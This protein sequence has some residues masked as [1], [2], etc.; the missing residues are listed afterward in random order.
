MSMLNVAFTYLYFKSNS[1]ENKILLQASPIF[2]FFVSLFIVSRIMLLFSDSIDGVSF[3]I[4]G[5]FITIA[6]GFISALFTFI[7]GVAG[8]VETFNERRITL[9][10]SSIVS[11]LVL[12]LLIP[13][14]IS[15]VIFL[16]IVIKK[17]VRRYSYLKQKKKRKNEIKYR[18]FKG[19]KTVKKGSQH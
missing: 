13:F 16:F 8:A 17:M 3:E 4:L 7:M 9:A 19:K 10:L 11:I 2:S 5:L 15:P 1:Q 6:G 14:F 18:D 12:P